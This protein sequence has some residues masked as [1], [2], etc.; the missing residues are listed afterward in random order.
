MT[1]K[2][3]RSLRTFWVVLFALI[4]LPVGAF[5]QSSAAPVLTA[6]SF[7]PAAINTG[8][9]PA[10][11]TVNFTSTDNFGPIFY[12]ETA[13]VDPS[14]VF[15]QRGAKVLSPARTP[16]TD[17]VA[18]TF[19]AFSPAGT[20]NLAYVFIADTSGGSL[21]LG[22]GDLAAAGFPTALQVSSIVDSQPPNL[23]ALSYP[24]SIDTSA[25]SATVS[26]NFS[27]TDDVS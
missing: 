23:T 5:A 24:A 13:F 12:F 11:V 20:W 3:R 15:F 2:A 18:I 26:V 8:G 16:A 21:F 25:A 17:S 9:A 1:F 14:G 19:P 4:A 10:T 27:L 7:S 22:T 6:L